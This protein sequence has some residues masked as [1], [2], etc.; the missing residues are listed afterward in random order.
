MDNQG[1]M[2]S[3][4]GEGESLS[5]AGNLICK[6]SAGMSG[7][8]YSI[9]E[10]R[11][12]PGQGAPMH[13]HRRED[14]MLCVV[15]GECEVVDA[16]GARLALPGSVVRL[17]R[18]A[19]HAFRNTGARTCHLIITTVPGGLERFFAAISQAVASGEGTPERLREIAEAHGIDFIS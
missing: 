6:V 15:E 12:A 10:F 11:L 17:P 4:P 13:V 9:L 16:E 2:V 14:E 5:A 3:L 1:V 8:A 18:G 7:G 19:R